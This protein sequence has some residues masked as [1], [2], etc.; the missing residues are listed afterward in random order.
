MKLKASR[1]ASEKLSLAQTAVETRVEVRA[2]QLSANG[3]AA[4]QGADR[5]TWQDASFDAST[6]VAD[7][8]GASPA[9]SSADLHFDDVALKLKA[10]AAVALDAASEIAQIAAVNLG[11]KSLTVALP[12]GPIDVRGDGLSLALSDAVFHSPADPATEMLRLGRANISGG[13]F[14]LKDQVVTVQQD[15]YRRWRGAD[16]AGH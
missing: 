10:L 13:M 15:R 1:L 6:I 9:A 3:L 14:R 11:A 16:L 12:K 8:G 4:Q 5:I 7:L 2:A